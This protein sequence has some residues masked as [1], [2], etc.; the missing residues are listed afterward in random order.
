MTQ[1][2]TFHEMR[3]T[4][5]EELTPQAAAVKQTKLLVDVRGKQRTR[6][7]AFT[8]HEGM[9]M[10]EGDIY[11]GPTAKVLEGDVGG[12]RGVSINAAS[13][14]WPKKTVRYLLESGFQ[15]ASLVKQAMETW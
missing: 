5:P 4:H 6:D 3:V 9:A 8:D 11:L 10:F 13:L 1:S 14:L 15:Y 2:G 7:I 12:T